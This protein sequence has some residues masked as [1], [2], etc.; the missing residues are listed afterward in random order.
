MMLEK[1]FWKSVKITVWSVCC[2][3]GG[4][5]ATIG[6]DIVTVLIVVD[7]VLFILVMIDTGADTVA[8]NEKFLLLFNSVKINLLYS[9]Y[10]IFKLSFSLL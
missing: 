8:V 7:V 6:V 3:D 9:I 2:W 10:L 4:T 5:D 1:Y